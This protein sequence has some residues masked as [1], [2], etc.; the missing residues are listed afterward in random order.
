MLTYVETF[1]LFEKSIFTGLSHQAINPIKPPQ[2]KKE[3]KIKRENDIAASVER[4]ISLKRN[5]IA[6]SLVPSP[7]IEIGIKVIILTMLII[8]ARSK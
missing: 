5:I 1:S 7:E 8:R 6:A 2:I 3:K 4:P